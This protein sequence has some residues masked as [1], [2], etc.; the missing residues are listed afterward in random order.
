M[1]RTTLTF[2]RIDNSRFIKPGMSVQ[3][4]LSC[5]SER[6]CTAVIHRTDLG[7]MTVPVPMFPHDR[8]ED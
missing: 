2:E 6:M 5:A 7:T 3:E 4:R 8:I 1:M